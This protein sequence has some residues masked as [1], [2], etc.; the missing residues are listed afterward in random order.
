MADCTGWI[1]EPK[2]KNILFKKFSVVSISLDFLSYVSSVNQFELFS[3]V[4]VFRLLHEGTWP[5]IMKF[6][7]KLVEKNR[8]GHFGKLRHRTWRS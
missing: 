5:F 6:H 7:E 3:Q 8:F 4:A 2:K 1:L